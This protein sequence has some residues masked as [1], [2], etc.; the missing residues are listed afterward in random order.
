MRSE[1]WEGVTEGKQGEESKHGKD[2]AR[3]RNG[4]GQGIKKATGSRQKGKNLE[5][6]AKEEMKRILDT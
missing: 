4:E 5:D 2:T 1:S 6:I 3:T